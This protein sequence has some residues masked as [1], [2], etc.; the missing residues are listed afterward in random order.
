[1]TQAIFWTAAIAATCF[2]VGCG[3]DSAE[4]TE[5]ARQ[6][7]P[8]ILLITVDTLR[9]GDVSAHGHEP[10]TM[11]FMEELARGGIRFDRAYSTAPWTTPSLVSILTSAYPTRHGV[12]QGPA[13][14]T[15][16][17][18][19]VIPPELPCLPL[20]LQQAGYRTFGLTANFGLPANRG[21]GR[22]FDNYRC[23]GAEDL[24]VFRTELEPWLT[25]LAEGE[26]W[27]LWLHLFDPH[28]PYTTREQWLDTFWPTTRQGFA[29]LDNV[30]PAELRREARTYT[31]AQME[32]VHALYRT[33][34]R[35]VDE[36]LREFFETLPRAAEALVLF[37]ADHGE[38]FMEHG[39][40][41]HGHTLHEELI[42]IP[43]IV[44]FPDRRFAGEIVNDPVSLVDVLPT[45]LS[46]V[47]ILPD[48]EAAG[49]NLFGPDG[50]QVPSSRR[51]FAELLR[52][53]SGLRAVI[54]QRFK[55]VK[56]PNAPDKSVL[57]DLQDDPGE[58]VN[59]V[60]VRPEVAG[61]LERVLD[62]F[63]DVAMARREQTEDTEI[64]AR[65]KAAL[66]ALG[67]VR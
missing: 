43:F 31:G 25:E 26:P 3:S 27:F 30:S 46:A 63:V 15:D 49:V 36:Y 4:R 44:R 23:I 62:G 33:E 55:F 18:W 12:G 58:T 13:I 57:T 34:I 7:R 37:S 19:E 24:D 29:R 9:A 1:M 51:I 59:L 53:T 22:G 61:E 47:G 39:G 41:L 14:A 32:Y 45:I 64:S 11:P 21:F 10:R 8:D 42:R 35:D 16:G 6:P 40:V 67:Y 5:S 38:E 48:P 50:V 65:Q 60:Q 66:R 17:T 28:G 2:S 54:D 52:G 56:N 20:A